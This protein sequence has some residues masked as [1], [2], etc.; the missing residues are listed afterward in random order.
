M[1]TYLLI[2]ALVAVVLAIVITYL[3]MH[4]RQVKACNQLENELIASKEALK[5]AQALREADAQAHEKA[6]KMQQEAFSQQLEAVRGQLSAE[7]E[8]LLKQREE[9]LQQKAEETFKNLTGPL[10]KD[11]KTMQE[12]FEAQKEA[13]SK[14]SATIKEVMDYAVKNLREQTASIG[15]K[16]D[17]LAQALKGQNKMT[18][19]WG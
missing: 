13:Q 11:L 8:K 9:A 17:N 6:L 2:A 16:A 12:A 3:V 15:S 5:S 7:T 1:N 14:G 10:G 18:G 19:T 4:S